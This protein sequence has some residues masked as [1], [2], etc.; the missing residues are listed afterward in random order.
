MN[1]KDNLFYEE[2]EAKL[3]YMKQHPIE[4][5]KDSVSS[6]LNKTFSISLGLVIIF[7]LLITLLGLLRWLD[8]SIYFNTINNPFY[9]INDFNRKFATSNAKFFKWFDRSK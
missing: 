9:S 1:E 5:E 6:K 2:I 4:E 3:E 7:G 8:E